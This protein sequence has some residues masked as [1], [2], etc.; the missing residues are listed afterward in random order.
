MSCKIMCMFKL[1]VTSC[2]LCDVCC[3]RYVGRI[4]CVL[5]SVCCD[6][7][8]VVDY[9]LCCVHCACGVECCLL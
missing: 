3:L 8:C 6:A 2:L 9:V 7:C 5:F 4:V 1:F